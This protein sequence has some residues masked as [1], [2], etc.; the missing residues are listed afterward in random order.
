V[1]IQNGQG[2]LIYKPIKIVELTNAS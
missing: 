1:V 2:G